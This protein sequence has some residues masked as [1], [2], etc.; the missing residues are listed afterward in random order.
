M[1]CWALF[2]LNTLASAIGLLPEE[3]RLEIYFGRW[4]LAIWWG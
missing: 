1:I 4:A 3:R 2:E